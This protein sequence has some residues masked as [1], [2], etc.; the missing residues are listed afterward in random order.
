MVQLKRVPA[1][2]RL[3]EAELWPAFENDLPAILGGL[4]DATSKAL[5]ILDEVERENNH[6]PRMADFAEFGEAFAR[7]LGRDPGEFLEAYRKKLDEQNR[8]ALEADV[9]G[10]VV[11][12][13]VENNGPWTGRAS[14]LLA[15]LEELAES[16]EFKI[17]TNAKAWPGAPHVLSKRLAELEV[18]LE[19]E[20][21]EFGRD[22]EGDKR[23]IVL[24]HTGTPRPQRVNEPASSASRRHQP[25]DQSN[26]ATHDA[27]DAT[28]SGDDA[29]E[30]PASPS[31]KTPD[32]ADDAKSSTHRKQGGKGSVPTEK[33]KAAFFR[34]HLSEP[35][36]LDDFIK[37]RIC[38]DE[39][40]DHEQEIKL[41][42]H[43]HAKEHPDAAGNSWTWLN[44]KTAEHAEHADDDVAEKE[45]A[46]R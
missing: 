4:Y 38:R 25:D 1:Q 14:E 33:G 24:Q 46:G 22:R 44:L 45:E 16:D 28:R 36:E 34:R 6:L 31:T 37:C 43:Q 12:K 27:N 18:N 42:L 26:D 41:H 15:E 2:D 17:D 5:H 23:K 13:F 8:A 21:V 19:E 3:K 7:A 30:K 9:V 40:E 10:D 20:G 32:D 11:L 29:T 35:T 39:I